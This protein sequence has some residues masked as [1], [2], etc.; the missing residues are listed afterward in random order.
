MQESELLDIYQSFRKG[1]EAFFQLPALPRTLKPKRASISARLATSLRPYFPSNVNI[2]TEL[3]GT[4]ILVWDENGL[5]LA[6]FWSSSYLAKKRKLSAISFHERE[7]TPLTLA[8]SLFPGNK[9]S[10]QAEVG[11]SL[12]FMIFG[13][14]RCRKGDQDLRYFTGVMP[15]FALKNLWNVGTSGKLSRETISLTG[16]EEYRSMF[17]ASRIT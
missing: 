1:M 8:C 6:L 4:D 7:K 15:V 17:F 11:Q 10:G 16:M 3:L 14:C 2:D 13:E 9:S 12:F 5:I